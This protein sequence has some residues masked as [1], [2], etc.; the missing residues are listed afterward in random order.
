MKRG[1][2]MTT[3]QLHGVAHRR[4]I[5]TLSVAL[6]A[7]VIGIFALAAGIAPCASAYPTSQYVRTESG[8]V[9]CDVQPDSVGCQYLPGFPQAPVDNWGGH[10]DIAK[11]TSG[12]AF[13]WMEGNL[14]TG[15]SA[16][17]QNDVILNYGQ[18]YATQGWTI[19]PSSDGTRFTNDGTGHG[20]FVSV[21][22]VSSF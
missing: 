7:E 9:R 22:N 4:V 10:P 12:G 19:L 6:G 2:I 21:D 11:L 20:M 5:G 3:C 13:S 14:A 17:P 8:K 16:D 15:G 1:F 18:S